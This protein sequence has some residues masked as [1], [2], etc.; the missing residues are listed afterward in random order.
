MTLRRRLLLLVLGLSA[1]GLLT[2][3]AVSVALLRSF[4]L[5]RVD[6][7][8]VSFVGQE[9]RVRGSTIF[10][11]CGVDEPFRLNPDGIVSEY[12][13]NG[14]ARCAPPAD[15]GGGPKLEAADLSRIDAPFGAPGRTAGH[16]YR[17][18]VRTYAN[19][20]SFGDGNGPFGPGHGG[21][22]GGPGTSATGVSLTK[23]ADPS[24]LGLQRVVAIDLAE[25]TSTWQ[26]QALATGVVGLV[27]LTLLGAVGMLLVRRDLR[28]L[29]LVTEAADQI[30]QGDLSLRVDV[31]HA[32][33][34]VG[35][36]GTAF[37]TM[38][39]SIESAFGE[40]QRSELKLR[41]FVADASH[42][43]RTPLTSIR[44]YAELERVGGA[45]TPEK[46]A[47]VMRNI[48]REATRMGGLVEDLLLL[49]KLDEEPP[50]RLSR[51]DV[52]RLAE[53][54]V[55]DFHA[56]EPERPVQT[57]LTRP[58]EVVVDEARIRQVLAN[59]LAN[60]R[61]HTAAGTPVEVSLERQ[62]DTAVL[63]VIDH[64]PGIP[65]DKAEQVFERFTRLDPSRA[66][67]SGG[68][69]LGLAI[70]RALVQAHHGDVVV[71][72]TPGGGA[73][74]VVTLPLSA[75]DQFAAG[76]TVA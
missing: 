33:N 43:L 57:F 49:A 50:L 34:E 73:T 30:S 64:G 19:P 62:V 38:V 59:L 71:L 16:T 17:V 18:R 22:D 21:D 55:N 20:G 1:I 9:P 7:Q 72:P 24:E 23:A 8:L 5:D 26:R 11:R 48:E 52:A 75:P 53:D 63:R 35:R 41:R 69:G 3:G 68:S 76:T 47:T 51:V 32:G 46:R 4:V 37:N 61:A 14:V 27:T 29:E 65:P 42:E 36:L 10:I 45:D 28:P 56:V 40:Q 25:A 44:G 12:Y 70:V 13:Y 58:V 74:F 54:A 67:T 2:A 66:R 39:A 31:P 6:K 60:A 15:P